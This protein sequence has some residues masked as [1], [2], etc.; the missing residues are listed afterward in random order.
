M[1]GV[2]AAHFVEA[3]PTRDGAYPRDVVT[4]WQQGQRATKHRHAHVIRAL[5]DERD[6]D[7]SRN[8][9]CTVLDVRQGILGSGTI[10]TP[11]R[12]RQSNPQGAHTH[13]SLAHVGLRV[14]AAIVLMEGC[15]RGVFHHQ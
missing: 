14:Y 3:A 5:G 2:V 13:A 12:Q 1:I 6:N 15:V 8:L 9:L 7:G 4:V 10:G 11:R